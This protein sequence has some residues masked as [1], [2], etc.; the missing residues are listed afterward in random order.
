MSPAFGKRGIEKETL[1]LLVVAV[2]VIVSFL[3]FNK[4]IASASDRSGAVTACRAS[5]E[6]NAHLRLGGF[7][8]PASVDCPARELQVNDKEKA[9]QNIAEEMYDCWYQYG[10]GRLPLFKDDATYCSVCAFVRIKTGESVKG[11]PYYLMSE[12]IPGSSGTLYYDYLQGYKT[13]RA[14]Q[15]IGMLK[16]AALLNTTT[17]NELK[18]GYTYAVIF[19]Y[20]KGEE[21]LKKYRE[22]FLAKTPA[23]KAGFVI[24]TA[25]ALGVLAPVGTMAALSTIGI[26][27]GPPGWV[28]LAAGATA[29]AVYGAAEGITLLF[30]PDNVPEWASFIVLREWSSDVGDTSFAETVLR[31]ELGCEYFPTKLG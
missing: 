22:H 5:V 1:I 30:S 8:F 24:G 6:R 19:Q 23:G 3:Y 27:A 28:V 7:E 18:P 4:G 9:N 13:G 14:E 31:D 17:A 20:I 11:L 10:E 25:G 2:L 15:A 16:D 29:L 26:V 12:Q 21:H